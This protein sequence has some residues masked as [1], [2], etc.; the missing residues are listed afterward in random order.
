MPNLKVD[1]YVIALDHSTPFATVV[2]TFK[3]NDGQVHGPF[4]FVPPFA[5]KFSDEMCIA[6][7]RATKKVS[8]I[9]EGTNTT[10]GS[11]GTP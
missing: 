2:V 9:E 7:A 11:Q 1:E 3:D 4:E 8:G 5:H 10:D 6:S